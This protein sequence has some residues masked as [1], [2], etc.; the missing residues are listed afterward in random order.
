M[1]TVSEQLAKTLVKDAIQFGAIKL[2]GT[3]TSGTE[4]AT[5]NAEAD[6]IYLLT[7]LKK[8]QGQ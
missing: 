2:K 5:Q 4:M 6:A 8:L 1:E 7:L 3:G